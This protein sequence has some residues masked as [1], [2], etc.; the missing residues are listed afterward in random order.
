MPENF[1]NS[2]VLILS[3]YYYYATYY[4]TKIKTGILEFTELHAYLDS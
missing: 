4:S 3:V 2:A 1:Q